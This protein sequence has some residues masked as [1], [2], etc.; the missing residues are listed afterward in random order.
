MKKKKIDVIGIATLI[1]GLVIILLLLISNGLKRQAVSSKDFYSGVNQLRN[2]IDYD[3][4]SIAGY[5]VQVNEC[6]KFVRT[7]EKAIEVLKRLKGYIDPYPENIE[8]ISWDII[9]YD[10]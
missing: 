10:E 4:V 2:Q 8:Y 3:R 1:L 9:Y 7:K 5:K 6:S